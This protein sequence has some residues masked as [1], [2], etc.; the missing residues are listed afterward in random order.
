MSS[1]TQHLIDVGLLKSPPKFLATGIQYE[2]VM[3]SIAYGVAEDHS[4]KDAYGFAITPRDW[5]FVLEE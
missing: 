5:V 3:G 2:V 1:K 4:D